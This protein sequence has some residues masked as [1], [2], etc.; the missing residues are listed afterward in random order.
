MN[1]RKLNKAT[2]A[3]K[4]PISVIE[5]LLDELHGATVFSK[6]DLKFGYHQII[7]R[8]E[9]REKTTFWTHE[10]HYEFLV[11]PFGLTNAPATFQSLM[12]QVFCPFLL[13]FVLVFFYEYLQLE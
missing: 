6:L 1:Y 3:N 7:M 8:E 13:R 11:I 10:G 2:I 12:N 4:F 9:D 5:E